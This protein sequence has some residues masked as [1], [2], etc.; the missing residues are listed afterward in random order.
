MRRVSYPE[1]LQTLTQDSLWQAHLQHTGTSTF[2]HAT[3]QDPVERHVVHKR[4]HQVAAARHVGVSGPFKLRFFFGLTQ[5]VPS[6]S[7][8]ITTSSHS[9]NIRFPSS[10]LFFKMSLQFFAMTCKFCNAWR[11]KQSNFYNALFKLHLRMAKRTPA[12]FFFACHC[13]FLH[14]AQKH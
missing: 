7:N 6:C 14:C 11:P 1:R 2:H 3:K 9:Q 8:L 10:F 5:R 4:R 13:I 12:V